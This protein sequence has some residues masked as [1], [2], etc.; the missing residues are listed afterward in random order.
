MISALVWLKPCE[1]K[2]NDD[3]YEYKFSRY[4]FEDTV[5][6]RINCPFC[7]VRDHSEFTYGSDAS[8][9]Y[10]ALDGS[11]EDWVKA[12]FERENVRGSQFE[13]WQHTSGCRQWLVV[14]RDT[15]THEIH[16]VILAHSGVEKTLPIS[17]GEAKA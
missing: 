1:A 10:P 17:N 8:I 2:E 7:G 5:L 12:V 9:E 16:S 3:G 11:M 14:E 6:L 15:M 4:S 13:T